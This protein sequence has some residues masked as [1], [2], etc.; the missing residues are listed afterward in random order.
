MKKILLTAIFFINFTFVFSQ[1]Y[2][3]GSGT[4]NT[5]SGTF[6][7]PGGTG[8]YPNSSN[9]TQTFCSN[10]SNCITFTFTAFN[11][12]SGW[13]YL[14]IYDGP[15]TLSPLLGSWTGTTSPGTKTST[16]TCLT[17]VFTSDAIINAAGWSA[18]ITCAACGTT[19]VTADDCPDAVSVCTNSSFSVDPNGF[20]TTNELPIG[21]VVN[22]STNPASANSGCLLSGEK[23]STWMIVNI[24]SNGT[25]EFSFG[26][27][28]VNSN[29]YDWIMWAY[30]STTCSQI[31]SNSIAPIRCNWN[32]PCVGYTGL[33]TPVPAGGQAGNFEPE[34]NVTCGQQYLICLSNYS[35]ATTSVPLNFFGTA[36]VSCSTF[37]VITVN[38]DT[39][40][41][42]SCAIL[43]ATGGTTYTWSPSTGLSSTTG[44]TVTAC[45]AST[46]TYTVTGT[47]S[48]GT[49]TA[50]STVTVSALPTL[51]MSS[52]PAYCLSCNGTATAGVSGGT[53]PYT[54]S[55][56][57]GGQTT[58]TATGL[59]AG[60]YTATVKDANGCFKTASVSVALAPPSLTASITSTNVT[61]F[62][63]CNGSADLTP[64]G[65]TAPYTYKWSNG[66]TTQDQL[67]TLCAGV[68]TATVRDINSCLTTASITLT[69]PFAITVTASS[70]NITCGGLCNGSAS[71]SGSGG[72][73][74]LTYTWSNGA[75]GATISSLCAG[76]YTGTVTDAKGCK[77]TSAVTIT[78]PG[79]LTSS[80]TK[81]TSACAVCMCKE[82]ALFSVSGGTLPIT[83]SWSNGY[84]DVYKNKLCPGTYAATATDA[85]GCKVYAS[86][87]LP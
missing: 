57:P 4:I 38:S 45:P 81:G 48:C 33:A 21:S 77:V 17:F 13:D 10:S 73:A 2:I 30:S 62:G 31:L 63:L 24:A 16:G 70:T 29:C 22:P 25:L 15:N 41:P 27:P 76:T 86:T 74:P 49:G 66:I 85:N 40:C 53:A 64:G 42:G 43:T 82:W 32:S 9:L 7:D 50:T 20:G 8:S 52:T 44:A 58:A 6:L 60:T 83:Y 84:T 55:W 87:T 54:Y 51:T 3:M 37:T 23:N 69:Q 14:Y 1:T 11:I 56:V 19:S 79:T 35:S 80:F 46:T 47:G 28:G 72:T 34:L 18:T 78:Q 61:C 67:G 12:E 71:I 65:G 5:C 26:T 68:Y 59:C 36:S 75:N 39:I